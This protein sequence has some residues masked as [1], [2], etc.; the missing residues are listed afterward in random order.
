MSQ[1]TGSAAPTTNYEGTRS[2]PEKMPELTRQLENLRYQN[3]LLEDVTISIKEKLKSLHLF[4][5]I[6]EPDSKSPVK[7]KSP[8]SFVEY[9]EFEVNRLRNYNNRLSD[10]LIHLKDVI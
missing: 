6:T 7:E 1:N 2:V 5:A 3:N 9:M 8:E 4:N 10:I